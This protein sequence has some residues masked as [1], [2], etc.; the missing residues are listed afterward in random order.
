[1][2]QRRHENATWLRTELRYGKNPED[3]GLQYANKEMGNPQPSS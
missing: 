3:D 2:Y 1:V